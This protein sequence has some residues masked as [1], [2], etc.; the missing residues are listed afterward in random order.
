MTPRLFDFFRPLSAF[1]RPWVNQSGEIA[2]YWAL[3]GGWRALVRS[4]YAQ[5]SLV[6]G[7]LCGGAPSFDPAAT[8]LEVVPAV[9]GF[10]VGALAI[11]LVFSAAEFF[12][13]FIA[14]SGEASVFMK[15]VANFV[16]FVF[17][18]VFA[19]AVAIMDLA[20]PTHLF[21]SV[22]CI[23]LFYSILMTF[24]TVMQLFQIATVFNAA[25]KQMSDEHAE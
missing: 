24:S 9:L 18:Q 20:H 2:R 23:A 5:V 6:L 12:A 19:L 14:G 10:T 17:V 16:H 21:R 7:L 11:V 1:F 15:M 8:T 25:K 3:Y 4:P 22:S 13:H